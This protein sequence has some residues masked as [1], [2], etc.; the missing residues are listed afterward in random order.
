MKSFLKYLTCQILNLKYLHRRY[1]NYSFWS[2]T[3]Y[4]ITCLSLLLIL[5]IFR[6]SWS[7]HQLNEFRDMIKK[8]LLNWNYTQWQSVLR[9]IWKVNRL[10]FFFS[11]AVSGNSI[12]AAYGTIIKFQLISNHKKCFIALHTVRAAD[13]E[14]FYTSYPYIHSFKFALYEKIREQPVLT[15]K[16]MAQRGTESTECF[17]ERNFKKVEIYTR[18]FGIFSFTLLSYHKYFARFFLLLKLCISAK[19]L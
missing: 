15:L 13:R 9:N 6:F 5:L 4:G 7:I 12:K 2:A 17:K 8:K 14:N 3:I 16:Q 19:F 11:F 10:V 18:E 1:E